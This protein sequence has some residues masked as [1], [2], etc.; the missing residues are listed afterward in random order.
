M[1]LKAK[2]IFHRGLSMGLEFSYKAF[3]GDD[4]RFLEPIHCLY[5]LDVDVAA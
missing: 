4:A 2:S 3:V 5:D 1:G